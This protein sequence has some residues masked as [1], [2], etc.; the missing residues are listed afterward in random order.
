[1]FIS[2]FAGRRP[3]D[4]SSTSK[5]IFNLFVQH[6]PR[7]LAISPYPLLAAFTS[8]SSFQ[9]TSSFITSHPSPKWFAAARTSSDLPALRNS[10]ASDA[11]G[12]NALSSLLPNSWFSTRAPR[13]RPPATRGDLASPVRGRRPPSAPA[14]RSFE[15]HP[16][17]SSPNS[18]P[19]SPWT[20]L[21]S[22]RRH[23]HR[24]LFPLAPRCT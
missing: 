18:R 12:L 5:K 6:R 14:P 22:R 15:S 23:P 4:L 24:S 2:R 16:R 1:M 19:P 17:Q 3:I 9:P 21:S 10:N 20:T 7:S 11:S 13:P 8:S